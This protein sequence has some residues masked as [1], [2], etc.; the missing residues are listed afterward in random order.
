MFTRLADIGLDVQRDGSIK[1]D[2]TK[3]DNALANLG[4]MKKLFANSDTLVP[5]N[6]GIATLLR[7]HGRPGAG[8]R[9]RDHHAAA[10][11]CASA[12]SER[13]AP[14]P[15]SRTASTQI[16]KRL[17]AQYTALDTQMGQLQQ[18]V[19]LRHAADRR[20]EQQQQQH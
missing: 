10:K 6:N 7:A 3:L 17:R 4:E 13:G 15:S 8:H 9:R 2:E 20:A 18:P 12:S 5:A 11:A 19:E 14:G 1:L 16:E